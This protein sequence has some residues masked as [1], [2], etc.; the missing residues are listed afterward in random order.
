M[1]KPLFKGIHEAVQ[2]FVDQGEIAGAVTMVVDK[3]RV[4]H[5]DAAGFADLASQTALTTE[6]LFWIASMTKPVTAICVMMLVDEGK[7]SLAEPI[8]NYLAQMKEL[9]TAD[10]EPVSMSLLQ[11][12]NHTSGM[13]E[14]P[15]PYSDLSLAGAADKYARMPVEFAPG[16]RW[17]YSQSGINTAARIVEVV[18]GL[19]FERF[20]Q[21][22]LCEP[23]GLRDTTFY[24]SQNQHRAL[25]KSYART[26]EGRLE[27][28]PIFLLAGKQP[29]DHQRLPAANAGL[30]S[31]AADYGKICQMLL[32]GGVWQ[33]RRI[34]SEA[35][36]RALGTPTTG[37]LVT[38]FTSGN[39]WGVGCCVVREPQGPTAMLS[40]GSY[41]H[42][43]AYGTQ[44]WIDPRRGR[45][46]LLF[47]QRANFPN[48][49]ATELRTVF[50]RLAT[51]DPV[52]CPAMNRITVPRQ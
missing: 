6:H 10:G 42:G 50:Q 26:P 39:A 23:L 51:N 9:K 11:T 14:L 15:A 41:G 27:E 1:R 45:A 33:G 44:A 17:Q 36:V 24:L 34:L 18:S 43:G 7:I 52:S 8:S 2:G 20:L 40:K 37:D 32:A 4:L 12:L 46:F 19:S 38:G 25:A 47:V 3:E 5:L 16:T 30:F 22:R 28:A 29:T 21:E 49:D 48:A 31:T 35:A 13:G